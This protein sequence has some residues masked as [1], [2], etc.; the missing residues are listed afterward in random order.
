M[1]RFFK[2]SSTINN[3]TSPTFMLVALKGLFYT[4]YTVFWHL[5]RS[6]VNLTWCIRWREFSQ[7]PEMHQKQMHQGFLF[8]FIVRHNGIHWLINCVVKLYPTSQ[9]SFEKA[10]LCVW[11]AQ[12]WQ[13]HL[14]EL[15]WCSASQTAC[16]SPRP[17]NENKWSLGGY[18][19]LFKMATSQQELIVHS[20]GQ[21]NL[22]ATPQFT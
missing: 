20:K 22:K 4:V 18:C 8:Y 11:W 9:F 21:V 6:M 7:A 2:E 15:S 17:L 10:N 1:H 16:A 5:N 12:T 19:M 3:F 14:T 13:F